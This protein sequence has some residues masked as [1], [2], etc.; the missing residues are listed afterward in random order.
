[1]QSLFFIKAT[2]KIFYMNK[3]NYSISFNY[4]LM[5]YS[6][7]RLCAKKIVLILLTIITTLIAGGKDRVMITL[8]VPQHM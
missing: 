2:M 8:V 4:V 6:Q 7:C 1:M 3:W 5:L